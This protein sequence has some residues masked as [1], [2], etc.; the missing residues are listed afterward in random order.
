[1]LNLQ[2]KVSLEEDSFSTI[3]L[4]GGQRKRLALLQCYLE[5]CPIYLF[6]EVAADQDPEFRR[7][8]YRELLT[9]MKEKGKIV[10]A[11]THDDHY[12]DVAD[13]VIKFDMGKLDVL[14]EGSQYMLSAARQ[15]TVS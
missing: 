1:M 5:D 15:D 6:D 10:I 3:D 14:R 11:I 4:S 13:R 2:D 8:F 9:R 12:F 7:F